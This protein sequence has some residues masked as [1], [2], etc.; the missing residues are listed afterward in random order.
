VRV[1]N[2]TAESTW[3]V[4]RL[5]RTVRR[6]AA[7]GIVEA[8]LLDRAPRQQGDDQLLRLVAGIAAAAPDRNC[9]RSPRSWRPCANARL[10][11][12]LAGISPLPSTCSLVPNSSGW[13]GP[14][15]RRS[16]QGSG[17]QPHDRIFRRSWRPKSGNFGAP[18][19]PL[20]SLA[21]APKDELKRNQKSK[22][23]VPANADTSPRPTES[24]PGHQAR[25]PRARIALAA[26]LRTGSAHRRRHRDSPCRRI[27]AV[28][29]AAGFD[30]G[31]LAVNS[32]KR[33]G[34]MPPTMNRR[35]RLQSGSV[36]RLRDLTLR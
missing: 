32:L 36:A 9:S 35:A 1:L 28:Y 26:P 31:A 12:E 29:G 4:E 33:G 5:R 21:E 16:I 34:A 25:P 18:P 24:D 19:C 7:E 14:R 3:T 15:Q 8:K 6:L 27:A 2:R 13:P 22:P 10:A 23:A 20:W 17:D 11:A 30:A